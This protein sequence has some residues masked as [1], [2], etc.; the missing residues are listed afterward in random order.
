MIN[1]RKTILGLFAACVFAVLMIFNVNST[2]EGFDFS[3]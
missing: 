2:E 1:Q 3:L